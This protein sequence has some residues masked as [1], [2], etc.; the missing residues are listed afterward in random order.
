MDILALVIFLVLSLIGLAVIPLGI[1]GTFIV[2][3]ASGSVGLLTGWQL[4]SLRLLLIFLGLAVLGEVS[5]AL[6]SLL[7][8][9]KFGASGFS[10]FWS[11][12]GGFVGAI[13][14]F[15]LPLIGSLVG[16]FVGAFLGAFLAELLTGTNLSE[17]MK[18]GIGVVFGKLFG[19]IL[20]VAIGMVMIFTVLIHF[21]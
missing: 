17:A 4:V 13:I 12:V 1:P 16:A 14:G 9:K 10:L 15:P 2:V 18:S 8:G 3:V 6:F 7:T 5:D 20:K 21:F 11:F 19:S